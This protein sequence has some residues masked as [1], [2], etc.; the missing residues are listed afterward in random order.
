MANNPA[1]VWPLTDAKQHLVEMLPDIPDMPEREWFA[2]LTPD[3]Q[4]I[5]SMLRQ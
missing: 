3:Q 4:A 1:V 5:H 2:T